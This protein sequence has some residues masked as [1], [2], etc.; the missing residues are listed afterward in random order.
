[1]KYLILSILFFLS[2]SALRS[3]D[4]ASKD[5]L[6][7]ISGKVFNEDGKPVAGAKIKIIDTKLGAKS[8][9][10]GSFI[11]QNVKYKN[12][13]QIQ[14]TSI[15]YTPLSTTLKR[16]ELNNLCFKLKTKPTILIIEDFLTNLLR[17]LTI[18]KSE[19]YENLT[20]GT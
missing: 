15:G 6:Y 18:L 17:K 11:I 14:I 4:S 19:P 8:G 1:M 13:I 3:Q 10:D 20:D 2:T 12:P 7:T 16:N 5:S 9:F